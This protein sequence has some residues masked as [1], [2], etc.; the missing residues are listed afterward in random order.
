MTGAEI[1]ALLKQVYATPSDLIAKT[2]KAI[3]Q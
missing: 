3:G 1:E 2:T